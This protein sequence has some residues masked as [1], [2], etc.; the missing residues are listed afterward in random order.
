VLVSTNVTRNARFSRSTTKMSWHAWRERL[1]MSRK[2]AEFDV[3]TVLE[4]DCFNPFLSFVS[5]HA[6]FLPAFRYHDVCP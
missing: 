2:V 6:K 4:P 3:K 5:S 1:R